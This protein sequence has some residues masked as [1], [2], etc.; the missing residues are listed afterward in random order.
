MGEGSSEQQQQQQQE[1]ESEQ[2]PAACA[3]ANEACCTIDAELED[4]GEDAEDILSSDEEYNHKNFG[5][6]QALPV[7]GDPDWS[8]DEPDSAEEYLRRV[9]YEASRCP[10]VV[11]A[12]L[13]AAA[14]AAGGH[15]AAR[16]GRQVL[17]DVAPIADA[18]DWAKPNR[19]WVLQF[20]AD[21]QA[22]RQQLQEACLAGGYP[23]VQVPHVNDAEAWDRA[24]F[25]HAAQAEARGVPAAA[26]AEMTQLTPGICSKIMALE[27]P[28]VISLFLRHS[29]QLEEHCP[30]S[31][32]LLRAQWLFAL[33]ARLEK[34]CH[35]QVAAA[36]RA[37][38]RHCCKL[39]GVVSQAGD[40]LLPK[41][42][43]LIVMAGAYFAQDEE[44]CTFVDS[45]DLI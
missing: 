25:G 34:P 39:R 28:E 21:F 35:P 44:L 22:L 43:V 42:N 2:E 12:E 36:L 8:L 7:E 17:P 15:A 6:F 37:V 3:A 4:A 26:G 10:R 24:C 38:L 29:Q 5:I 14:A 40:P 31:L 32:P 23:V 13:P 45:V 27:Q 9:R 30:D 19:S 1:K 33:A 11:R 20:V 18:P 41:L 16:S